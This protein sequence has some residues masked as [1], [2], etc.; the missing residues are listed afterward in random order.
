[1]V[2]ARKLSGIAIA[3]YRRQEYKLDPLEK[4][5]GDP[6]CGR[7]F[8]LSSLIGNAE[9]RMSSW[10]SFAGQWKAEANAQFIICLSVP[11]CSSSWTW[12]RDLSCRL[13]HLP[14]FYE[15]MNG[16]LNEL[17]SAQ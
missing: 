3:V 14:V 17:L 8:T 11:T 4:M 15:V 5:T 10:T 7:M 2:L 6:R 9:V 13:P 16:N 12:T 1:M